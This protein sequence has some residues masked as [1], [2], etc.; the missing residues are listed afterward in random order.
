MIFIDPKR[1]T[2][3]LQKEKKNNKRAIC[4]SVA[5]RNKKY[6]DLIDDYALE[7]STGRASTIFRIV[8][9]YNTFKILQETA[10]L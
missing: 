9:E 7:W 10:R 1:E 2:M 8:S 4:L 5:Q 6:I 3:Q